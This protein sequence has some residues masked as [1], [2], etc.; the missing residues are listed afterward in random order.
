MN[1][2]NEAGEKRAKEMENNAM[3]FYNEVTEKIK[4]YL[5]DEKICYHLIYYKL[6]NLLSDCITTLNDVQN[7]EDEEEGI[8][9]EKFFDEHELGDLILFFAYQCECSIVQALGA[10]ELAKQSIYRNWSKNNEEINEPI[11]Q[12]DSFNNSGLKNIKSMLN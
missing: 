4:E 7:A 11:E 8:A 9:Q 6:I 2:E 12:K 10:I 5:K 1:K 3:Q